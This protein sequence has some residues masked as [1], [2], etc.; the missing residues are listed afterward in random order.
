MVAWFCKTPSH[1]LMFVVKSYLGGNSERNY[2]AGAEDTD[3]QLRAR[4]ACKWQMLAGDHSLTAQLVS[5][6]GRSTLPWDSVGQRDYR[7]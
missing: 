1:P 5:G 3:L 4:S 2:P 7:F 6:H